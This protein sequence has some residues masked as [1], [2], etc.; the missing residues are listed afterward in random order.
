MFDEKNL[1]APNGK[2]SNLT[3][4]QY[5]L[6]RTPE[7][8]VWFG[9]WI[10]A[11]ETKDYTGVSKVVDE[12]GE[13]LV[14][15]HGTSV[16]DLFFEF[17]PYSFFSNNINV[18]KSYEIRGFRKIK[19]ENKVYDCFLKFNNPYI[20]KN[21]KHWRTAIQENTELY[22][23]LENEYNYIEIDKWKN[24]KQKT[25]SFGSE[26]QNSINK[27]SFNIQQLQDF[28]DIITKYNLDIPFFKKYDSII[29]KNISD[30][31]HVKYQNE[32][33]NDYLAFNSN[34]IKL[35]D[36]T[37]TTFDSDNPDIRFNGGGNTDNLDKWDKMILSL[38][39][40]PEILSYPEGY[41]HPEKANKRDYLFSQFLDWKWN[42]DILQ[43]TFF[44]D[45]SWEFGYKDGT[46]ITVEDMDGIE[47]KKIIKN[48][49]PL[50]YDNIGNYF[51]ISPKNL[52]KIKKQNLAFII[53]YTSDSTVYWYDNKN[54]ELIKQW[55]GWFEAGNDVSNYNDG[56]TII[57]KYNISKNLLRDIP[58]A[59]EL[60]RAENEYWI[61]NE[62]DKD[63]DGNIIR[64]AFKPYYTVTFDTE[65]SSGSSDI[66]DYESLEKAYN[67]ANNEKY[68]CRDCNNYKYITLYVKEIWIYENN[69]IYDEAQTFA[70]DE[71]SKEDGGEIVLNISVIN[72]YNPIIYM[73]DFGG[74]EDEAKEL[75]DK[76]LDNLCNDISGDIDVY[77]FKF[78][79]EAHNC[80]KYSHINILHNGNEIGNIKLR[81]SDHAYNPANN[82]YESDF[83][84]VEVANENLTKNKFNGSYSLQYEGDSDYD[85]I[86]YDVIE[87]IK[88]IVSRWDLDKLIKEQEENMKKGG[89]I[90][91]VNKT[92]ITDDKGA[93]HVESGQAIVNAHNAQAKDHKHEFDGKQLTH[94]EIISLINQQTGGNAMVGNNSKITND[95][96]HGGVFSGQKHSECSEKGCGIKGV[97]VDTNTRIEV[98]DKEP[99]IKKE[100]VQC[101]CTHVFDGKTMTNKEIL[102]A[103]NTEGG[104]GVPIYDK[105][106]DIMQNGGGIN[107]GEII[108]VYEYQ[109]THGEQIVK[110]SWNGTA[111]N[112]WRYRFENAGDILREL[113]KYGGQY[114][115]TGY[116]YEKVDKIDRFIKDQMQRYIHPDDS[117][118]QMRKDNLQNL[119]DLYE[120]YTKQPIKTKAQQQ[121]RQL[122][123]A[124]ANNDLIKAKEIIDYFN[125]FR[126][127]NDMSIPKGLYAEN[128]IMVNNFK[129]GGEII[130]LKS[131]KDWFK[132]SKV[133]GENGNPLIVYHGTVNK[134]NVFKYTAD[135]GFHFGNLAQ[136]SQAV[137]VKSTKMKPDDFMKLP[138]ME[139]GQR[140]YILPCYLSIQNPFEMGDFI[141]WDAYYMAKWLLS[142]GMFSEDEFNQIKNLDFNPAEKKFVEIMLKKGYDG[143]K[144]E[145]E[146]EGEGISWIAFKPEQIKLADGSNTTFDGNNP[147]IRFNEGGNIDKQIWQMTLKEYLETVHNIE[148]PKEIILK[149]DPRSSF[150]EIKFISKKG[151][152][153]YPKYKA[154]KVNLDNT[155]NNASSSDIAETINKPFF[156]NETQEIG[157]LRLVLFLKGYITDYLAQVGVFND[158]NDIFY[159]SHYN[160]VNNA[161]S[162]GLPVPKEVVNDYPNLKEKYSDKF[163]NKQT[164]YKNISVGQRY[165]DDR[166]GDHFFVTNIDIISD[167]AD[168]R[169][170]KKYDHNA[171]LIENASSIEASINLIHRVEKDRF[172]GQDNIEKPQAEQ[173]KETDNDKSD[174][175][176]KK[177]T[178]YKKLLPIV[179]ADKKVFLEKKIKAFELLVSLKSK[180]V[181]QPSEKND[182]TVDEI[183][184]L[185]GNGKPLT[186]KGKQYSVNK[187]SYGDYFLE[188]YGKVLSERDNFDDDT[189]W[190]QLSKD[191]KHYLI[192]QYEDVDYIPEKTKSKIK[193]LKLSKKD[194]EYFDKMTPTVIKD[195]R[196][197]RDFA[198]T[199][200]SIKSGLYDGEYKLIKQYFIDKGII[201]ENENYV[202]T[203]DLLEP[204]KNKEIIEYINP[205]EYNEKF[206]NQ[207][208]FYLLKND[209]PVIV[210]DYNRYKTPQEYRIT[211]FKNFGGKDYTKWVTDDEFKEMLSEKYDFK[212]NKSIE[213]EKTYFDQV[214]ETA[215]N[216]LKIISRTEKGVIDTSASDKKSEIFENK[217]NSDVADIAKQN[218]KDTLQFLYNNKDKDFHNFGDLHDFVNIIN[219]KINKGIVKE[220]TLMRTED[221]GKFAYTKVEN[222]RDAHKQFIEEFFNR[223]YSR[224]YNP[225]ETAAWLHWRINFTDHFFADGCSKTSEALAAW[226]L[227]RADM[228]IYKYKNEPDFRKEFYNF[229]PK[230]IK[231]IDNLP[232]YYREDYKM[233]VEYFK[234]LFN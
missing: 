100:S 163:V 86:V 50:E 234:T 230:E 174:F 191:E 160:L 168:A 177:I 49:K 32:N 30:I 127:I 26:Y 87:R 154:V 31:G 76:V 73:A 28:L 132:D 162:Q 152:Q 199:I 106:G 184:D 47:I 120:A 170:T 34:Q 116:I 224:K 195:L 2:P 35:A 69:E 150:K 98:E 223:L 90:D 232:S 68:E 43:T 158:S 48:S 137:I 88:E 192:G 231:D 208:R 186:Y 72:E 74:S 185:W 143:I 136:A 12:N 220:G 181:E 196:W 82:N 107:N 205:I 124:L 202:E 63:S 167:G 55:T 102:T 92:K 51:E 114:F 29:F 110:K 142:K 91:G 19:K 71:L 33:G 20:V 215:L 58:I 161:L 211:A 115:S 222:L 200:M 24:E 6:V 175:L 169:I 182:Y 157:R 42:E 15:Y 105:G 147:D 188:P 190:L 176:Q 178:A 153:E 140:G 125:N 99:I 89:S 46:V 53:W 129:H 8:I 141:K 41:P 7:F 36:G 145:N 214:I 17:K 117:Y 183:R 84:S 61:T 108:D 218:F 75:L 226:V 16:T 56:G 38:R 118:E 144:Y 25:L 103:I 95:A 206:N 111:G 79:V 112:F 128:L 229:A 40:N 62:T 180:Q 60:I 210:V 13:P 213:P 78:E 122:V 94:L 131:F 179:S 126:E 135:I 189:I 52:K 216:N 77:E 18:A 39:N 113:S 123:L 66:D 67:E 80:S 165:S 27:K 44:N 156:Q 101:N 164:E 104:W 151:K 171:I 83:I 14:V 155:E 96:R 146:S 10:K 1:I 166:Y 227:M 21:A 121:A 9:N 172:K 81:I 204:F 212:K 85:D 197:G 57:E 3:K 64:K 70:L 148:I 149:A 203:E 217:E 187:M 209:I 4:G 207:K 173:Q 221:S 97:V 138:V 54:K 45:I 193:E 65:Y 119:L 225:I 109:D 37:N 228:S 130:N 219:K 59:K 5:R 134:F 11:Y 133:V 194:I 201:D 93:V 159:A 139:G 198:A 233:W 22:E 23:V